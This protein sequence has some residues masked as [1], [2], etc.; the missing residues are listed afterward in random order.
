MQENDKIVLENIY[1]PSSTELDVIQKVYSKYYKWRTNLT[2][3]WSQFEGMSVREYIKTAREKFNG[4]LPLNPL[5]ERKPYVSKEFRNSAEQVVTFV[6]NLLQNPEFYGE[7]G[8]DQNIAVFLNALI[9]KIRNGTKFKIQDAFHFLQT[10]ID[11]TGIVYVS[12]NPRKRKLKNIK[13]FNEETG[14]IEFDEKTISD[15]SVEEIWIDPLDIFIPKIFEPDIDK[16]GELIW[17]KI[18]TWSD[19]KR[20]Y[21]KY[22]LNKYVYPGQKL[23]ESSIFSEMLDK[24][25]LTSEKI[26]IVNYYN[27]EEDE[28]VILANGVFLNPVNAKTRKSMVSPLPWNHKELPFAKTIYRFTSPALFWGASLMHLV[29]DEVEAYNNLIEMSLDRVYR[30]I[31]PPVVTNDYSVPSN[32]KLESGKIYVSRGD[33]KELQM[34][35][36]DPNAFNVSM[37][38]QN[39]ISRNTTPLTPPTPNTRQPRSASEIIS[40]QQKELQSYQTQ[41]LFYQDLLEQKIW[42]AVFNGIQYLTVDVAKKMVGK[43]KFEKVLMVDQIQTPVGLSSVKVKIKGENEQLSN[44]VE[45]A[46]ESILE[47]IQN[48]KRVEVVEIAVDALQNLKFDVSVRF[49]IENTPELKKVLFMNFIQQLFTLFPDIGIDKKKVALRLF[50]VYNENPADYLSDEVIPSLFLKQPQQQPIQ[51]PGQPGQSLPQ[52]LVQ[53]QQT[54]PTAGPMGAMVKP[55][56]TDILTQLQ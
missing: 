47:S 24:A 44:P 46:R 14:E 17:R 18:M 10:I 21:G 6:S 49:D 4:I 50:E 1:K 36:L 28:Y 54:G 37:L 43:E 25:I 53:S 30:A 13:Y 52:Q 41:K 38:L 55:N 5:V 11:G 31:N 29:K 16:Q 8:L 27:T 7:E 19:F 35:P 48:K 34:S 12:W 39:N 20:R 26:E 15:N 40:R 3:S 33:W 2:T 45:L 32:I 9:K 51:Q 22:T 42:L 23:A 56:L